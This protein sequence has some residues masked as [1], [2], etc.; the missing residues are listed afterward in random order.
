MIV[1]DRHGHPVEIEDGEAIPDGVRVRCSPRWRSSRCHGAASTSRKFSP[2]AR[3][4][5]AQV[6][7]SSL[8]NIR[9]SSDVANPLSRSRN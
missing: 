3:V 9:L 6:M 4:A 2:C 7:R 5:R 1:D 8:Q